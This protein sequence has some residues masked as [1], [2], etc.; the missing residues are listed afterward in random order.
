MAASFPDSIG[1]AALKRYDEF[2]VKI[3][4][5]KFVDSEALYAA[6]L[7]GPTAK[8]YEGLGLTPI[9]FGAAFHATMES[10]AAEQ[11][12]IPGHVDSSILAGV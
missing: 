6:L 8:Q 9:R 10:F 7:S 2:V 11:A 4:P 5:N 12:N 3:V 1:V